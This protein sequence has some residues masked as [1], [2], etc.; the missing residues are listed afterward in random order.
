[1]ISLREQVKARLTREQAQRVRH[2]MN[3]VKY[4]IKFPYRAFRRTGIERRFVPLPNGRGWR[5]AIPPSL[6]VSITHG[7]VNFRYR[8]IVMQKHPV[9]VALYM[10]LIWETKPLTI[11]EIGSQAGGSAVWLADTLKQF[12]IDGRVVSIDLYPPLPPYLPANVSF[13][14]GDANDLASTLTADLLNSFPRPWLVIEDASHQ[15]AATLAV[16]R[17]FDPLLRQGEYIVVEDATVTE[18][19]V[20]ARFQGGPARSIAEFLQDRG[21]DYEIDTRYCDHYG[22]NVTGN[23]NGYLRKK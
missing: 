11:I 8:D 20:D 4:I 22:R 12:D 14:R 19:G 6:H 18:M 23:P 2:V 5:T 1:M 9:E 17:F 3:T 7:M 15:Y 21:R 13:M 10:R 16:M